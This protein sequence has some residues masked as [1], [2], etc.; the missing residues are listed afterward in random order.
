M[1]EDKDMNQNEPVNSKDELLNAI[2]EMD[3]DMD[4]TIC[5]TDEETGEEIEFIVNDTFNM[6]GKEYVVLLKPTEDPDADYEYIIMETV[7]SDGE[8]L[9]QTLV[10]TEADVIYDYYDKL[11]DELYGDDEES[12]E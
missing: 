9:L 12:D 1:A 7:E 3:V 2:S 6:N 11:C 10:G 4:R 5:L 8:S